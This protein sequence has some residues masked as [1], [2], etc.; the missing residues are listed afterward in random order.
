MIQ[1]QVHCVI[2]CVIWF[3]IRVKTAERVC[4]LTHP[5]HLNISDTQPKT[6]K[7]H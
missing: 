7:R 1:I 4:E 2:P 6:I 5:T 3:Y